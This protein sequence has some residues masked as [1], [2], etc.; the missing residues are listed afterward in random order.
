MVCFPGHQP[1]RR[2]RLLGGGR[3][4]GL[5]LIRRTLLPPLPGKSKMETRG[6]KKHHQ[7]PCLTGDSSD[8][9]N[10]G[11]AR[12]PAAVKAERPT[13]NGGT[14]RPEIFNSPGTCPCLSCGAVPARETR[15]ER[16]E[17]AGAHV[18]RGRRERALARRGAR[19]GE[20]AQRRQ[21]RGADAVVGG[22]TVDNGPR[23]KCAPLRRRKPTVS[24][25]QRRDAFAPGA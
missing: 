12:P 21:E 19:H 1:P 17:G 11:T 15:S 18:G 13:R 7:R 14:R 25:K 8:E 5:N 23:P 9:R 2:V 24:S 22:W 16:A 6:G 10:K 3:T 20:R 4:G